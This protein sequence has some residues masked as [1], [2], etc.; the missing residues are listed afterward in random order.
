[1]CLLWL[2]CQPLSSLL[3]RLLVRLPHFSMVN[4]VLGAAVVPELFQR[5]AQP[6]R[7]ATEA[8]KLL[9][10]P[11]RVAAMRRALAPL[12]ERLG[13]GGAS[14][15]AAEVIAAQPGGETAA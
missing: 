3:A 5:Q 12:R 14:R 15:R 6:A 8:E 2:H 4:L 11:A 9:A 10:S 1:M 7:L 13:E